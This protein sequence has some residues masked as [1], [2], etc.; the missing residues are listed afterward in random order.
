M[1]LLLALAQR[2]QILLYARYGSMCSLLALMQL[3]QSL[4]HP[5][6]HLLSILTKLLCVQNYSCSCC[7]SL[8]RLLLG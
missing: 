5:S 6:N 3:R 2:Q 1:S 4:L 8:L 7:S